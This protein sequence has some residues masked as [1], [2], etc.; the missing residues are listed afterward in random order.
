[1]APLWVLA[2][3]LQGGLVTT[4]GE[5]TA[6]FT[7]ASPQRPGGETGGGVLQQKGCPGLSGF[8]TAGK[9]GFL[10]CARNVLLIN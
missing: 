6:G 10:Q 4:R 5:E 3:P 1:M 2:G 7:A 9:I 8:A